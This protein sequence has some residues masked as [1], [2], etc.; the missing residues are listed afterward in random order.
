MVP[1]VVFISGA[2]R[3]LGLGLLQ[4]YLAL[5]GHTVISGNHNPAHPSSQA[6]ADL[7]RGDGSKLI[8]VKLDASVDQDAFAAVQELQEKHGINYLDIVVA[9]AGISYSWPSVAQ[10]KLDDLRNH[11]APNVYG[12]IALYQ[13]TRALLQ[14]SPR[15][16]IFSPVGSAAGC[17]TCFP[18]SIN[19]D[20]PP[21]VFLR[22]W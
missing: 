18:L 5:P 16:P 8:V 20:L 13:A 14:N 1:T 12:F 19:P 7:P 10:L 22:M 11:M 4:R 15:E 3:G 6:L 9:N 17:I 2:N 21:C